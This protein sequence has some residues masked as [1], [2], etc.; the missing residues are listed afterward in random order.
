MSFLDHATSLQPELVALRRSLHAHPEVGNDLPWTQQRIV[1]ALDGLDLEVT[2]GHSVSSVV[3]VLRGA[4]PGPTVLLRGD[5]DGLPVTEQ[6]GLEYASTTGAMHACGHDLHMAGL[7]GAAHLLSA[8]R[9]ELAGSVV[10][11][12]QPGRRARAVPSP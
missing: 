7:V 4:R 6:T 11:M 10:F 1:E 8:R 3:A 12:F 2:L 5:M 9:D